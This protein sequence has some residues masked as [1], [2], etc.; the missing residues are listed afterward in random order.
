MI[1]AD[2]SEVIAFLSRPETYGAAEVREIDTHISTVFLAGTKAYKLKRAVVFS[3]LDFGTLERRRRFCEA[4]VAVNRR[5]AP[6]IYERVA[7]VTREADGRLALDGA[8]EPVE[9]VVVMRRFDDSLLFD[10]LAE[11]GALDDALMLRLADEIVRFH[12]EAER[13]FE[14]GGSGVMAE[15]VAQNAQDLAR[16]AG[17]VLDG[18]A[19]TRFVAASQRALARVAALLEARRESGL[20]R[21]CHGDLH[22]RNICLY[23]GRPLLFDAIEFSE[24]L[25]SIDVLYDL[26]FLLMD[27]EHGGLRRLGNLV[28]NRYLAQSAGAE[29]I[30]G[31]AALPLFLACRA[32]VRAHVGADAALN[33]RDAAEKSRLIGEAQ[34][35]LGLAGALI[36]PPGPRLVGVGGVSGTGK[37]T[38]ARNLAPDLDPA[39]GALVLRSDTI[40]KRLWGI[41]EFERLPQEAYTPEVTARVY[42]TIAEAAEAALASGHSVIA[43]AVHARAEERDRLERLAARFSVPFAGLWLEAPV[44]EL[45][46]RVE[47]RGPDASDATVAVLR[48]QLEMP[49]GD[50]AWRRIDAGGGP[51]AT[52]SAARAALSG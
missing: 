23:E 3:Y 18:A 6:E 31:L 49:L 39:P 14:S 12:E 7:G 13:R 21:R 40:R 26:A 10:R 16:H 35:Y 32:A 43:D 44:G 28:F 34:A 19:V 52:L 36:A 11:R 45:E 5:T 51:D 17:T 29:T 24:S 8:G 38:L 2:Q 30:G 48:R 33:Q 42:G 47:R 15:V 4:E 46:R 20:V 41:G 37:S 1:V 22:L 9:Y 50:I 25:A 27:L